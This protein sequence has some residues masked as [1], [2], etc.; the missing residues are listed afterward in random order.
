MDFKARV[1]ELD[2]DS[3]PISVGDLGNIAKNK[4]KQTVVF[5]G[6]PMTGPFGIVAA[7][8]AQTIIIARNGPMV[9]HVKCFGDYS[10]TKLMAGMGATVDV[11]FTGDVSNHKVIVQHYKNVPSGIVTVYLNGAAF[12]PSV[13]ELD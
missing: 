1:E 8:G 4:E 7:V 5:G 9:L 2:R 3:E 13:R 12:V 10:V 6:E 11:Y